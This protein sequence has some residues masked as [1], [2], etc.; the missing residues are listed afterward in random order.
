M[1]T[2]IAGLGVL[3]VLAAL[4]A[5]GSWRWREAARRVRAAMAD[6]AGERASGPSRRGAANLPLPVQRYLRRALP[7]GAAP[8][9]GMRMRQEGSINLSETGERWTPFTAEQWTALRT[10]GFDWEARVRLIPGLPILVRDAY[11]GGEGITEASILGLWPLARVRGSGGIAEDQLVRFLAEAPW[12]PVVLLPG[13]AVEWSEEGERSARATIRQ[14]SLAATATF[15]FGED[16]FVLAVRS[17]ARGR[18]AG[19][20]RVPTPW[21]GRFGRYALREGMW[22]PLEGEVSWILPSGPHSYWRGRI[23]EIHY[24]R[25]R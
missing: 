23:A 24:E 11:A 5:A 9:D 18:A 22:I 4:A 21:Q 15:V 25:A 10:P 1:W 13:G 3:A 7:G 20:E 2:A 19:G 17:R 6:T 12:Y 14:G 8:I 16:D